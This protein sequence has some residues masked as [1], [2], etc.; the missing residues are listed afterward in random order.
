MEKHG[1]ESFFVLGEGLLG[2]TV[3]GREPQAR[4]AAA[5]ATPP[6]RFSRMGPKGTERQLSESNRKKLGNAMAAGGGGASQI[7]AGF[8]YLGQFIDHDLTFD[9]TNV[10]LGEHVSPTPAPAGPLAEP[11]SRLALRGR[12]A[13]SRL[14]EVLRGG[15]PPPQDGKDGRRSSGD[16][17]DGRLR[18][19][20]RRRVDGGAEAQGDHPRPQKRR[21]P[22]GRPDP[23]RVDPLPQPRRR[24]PPRLGPAGASASRRRAS[25]SPS[26]TSG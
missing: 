13:G 8:T 11:R 14:G 26:T 9:K 1:S 21:E 5:A 18:P 6:F 24:H 25:S 10:M 22:G 23:P 15:R 20:P 16:R 12:T 19:S 4:A 7:P 17:R 2:E 3:G